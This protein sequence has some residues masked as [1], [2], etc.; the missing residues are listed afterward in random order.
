M[1]ESSAGTSLRSLAAAR[2]SGSS[3]SLNERASICT[4]QTAAESTFVSSD[5]EDLAKHTDLWFTDGS[6][7]LRAESTIYRV[8]ISQLSRH[9]AFFRDL[10]TLPQ[11][12]SSTSADDDSTDSDI[13][14]GCPL[15]HLH[16]AAEDVSNLLAALYDGP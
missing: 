16:D 4:F 12:S 3:S 7:I 13:L 14:D 2:S 15:V 11:S 6:V 9:S 8:H 1:L 5:C 10:F